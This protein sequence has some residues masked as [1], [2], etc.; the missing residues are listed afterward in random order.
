MRKSGNQEAI[1]Q[2]IRKFWQI[3]ADRFVICSKI[4]NIGYSIAAQ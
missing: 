2:A 3:G 1:G 4:G